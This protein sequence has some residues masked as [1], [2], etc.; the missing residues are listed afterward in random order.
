MNSAQPRT[1]IHYLALNC[2]HRLMPSLWVDFP[3]MQP[4]A[5]WTEVK[6]SLSSLSV[7]TRSPAEVDG[8]GRSATHGTGAQ[9]LNC[10]LFKVKS[11]HGSVNKS[12]PPG[13]GPS[14]F[15]NKLTSVRCCP[16]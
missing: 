14:A 1:F 6:S 12:V 16:E 10:H 5:T 11:V 15:Y 3:E 13:C 7:A 2:T 9:V 4:A 8:R